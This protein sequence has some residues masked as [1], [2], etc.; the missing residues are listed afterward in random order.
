[1]TIADATCFFGG[2][3][4]L[5]SWEAAGNRSLQSSAWT[6]PMLVTVATSCV[7]ARATPPTPLPDVSPGPP[8][9]KSGNQTNIK[10]RQRGSER[11]EGREGEGKERGGL[12]CS[13]ITN[14]N[15]L[16]L[17]TNHSPTNNIHTL[18]FLVGPPAL[19]NTGGT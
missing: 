11:E 17:Q 8:L 7:V 14:I 3:G 19:T 5:F 2:G 9:P 16:I 10:E 18:E 4:G 13:N 1:M 15:T 6:P 12:C